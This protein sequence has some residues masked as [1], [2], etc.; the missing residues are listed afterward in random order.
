MTPEELYDEAVV[1]IGAPDLHPL[2]KAMLEECCERAIENS[3]LMT[4]DIETIKLSVQIGFLTAYSTLK[5]TLKAFAEM[6][7][8]IK[9][10]YR[11]QNF[12][13]PSNSKFLN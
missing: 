10:N 6:S 8:E 2:L 3:E 11:G 4:K 13:F 12:V 5:S 9:L 1:K 7:D